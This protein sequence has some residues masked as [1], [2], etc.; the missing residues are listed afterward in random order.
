MV[1]LIVGY[2]NV[3]QLEG[4]PQT[5]TY[6][7]IVKMFS[8]IDSLIKV[9][10]FIYILATDILYRPVAD[11][12]QVAV[13]GLSSHLEQAEDVVL[14]SVNE[15]TLSVLEKHMDAW[16]PNGETVYLPLLEKAIHIFR[17]SPSSLCSSL[18]SFC[19]V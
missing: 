7:V 19:F 6:E 15:Y 3:K 12:F 13:V 5:D 9:K 14:K 8:K 16:K 17:R 18:Y 10:I 4:V 1:Y 2:F 11:W